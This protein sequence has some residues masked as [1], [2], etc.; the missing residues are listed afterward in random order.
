MQIVAFSLVVYVLPYFPRDEQHPGLSSVSLYLELEEERMSD[1]NSYL[2]KVDHLVHV[3]G[4]MRQKGNAR[5]L[6]N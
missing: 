2:V 3:V 5:H 4:N 6:N 1:P